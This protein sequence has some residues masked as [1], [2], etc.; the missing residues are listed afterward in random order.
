MRPITCAAL[1][2]LFALA[3][4][5]APAAMA[6]PAD[7]Q[8]EISDWLIRLYDQDAT[9]Y[10]CSQKLADRRV[11]FT[12]ITER[13]PY[14]SRPVRE[15]LNDVIKQA[16][17][18][19]W[20]VISGEAVA[21]TVNEGTLFARDR[22]SA[23]EVLAEFEE[24]QTVLRATVV[25]NDIDIA[26]LKLEIVLTEPDGR[27]CDT[28]TRQWHF[29]TST[30]AR[31]GAPPF[32]A[33]AVDVYDLGAT[34][35]DGLRS[36]VPPGLG[37]EGDIAFL[38]SSDLS[39]GRCPVSPEAL[40]RLLYDAARDIGHAANRAT[41]ESGGRA[42][43][44]LSPD[45]AEQVAHLQ[46]LATASGLVGDEAQGDVARI[47][48]AWRDGPRRRPGESRV[49]AL[50]KG[51]LA[52]CAAGGT[53][54][55]LNRLELLLAGAPEMDRAGLSLTALDPPFKVGD[56]L[57][58]D[59][60]MAEPGHPYCWA[61]LQDEDEANGLIFYPFSART[62]GRVLAAGSHRVP[63][64][65]NKPKQALLAPGTILFHCF[66]ARSRA[67]EPLLRRWIAHHEAQRYLEWEEV[68]AM[69]RAFRQI[70]NIA[71]VYAWI[72]IEPS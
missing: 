33:T 64:G 3:L 50:P 41:A 24:V 9:M 46:V 37:P 72:R 57:A 13:D 31:V 63:E 61:L 39:G 60:V 11:R 22:V 21:N 49:V 15:K 14:L 53:A 23:A 45:E 58:L 4:A 29:D 56:E 30:L 28:A 44:E 32:S 35:R 16:I 1:G 7:L 47:A 10:A 51:T 12:E 67:P 59:F 66:V 52:R 69:A 26:R 40:T 68:E 5:V 65:L 25:R 38:V 48:F 6:Q 27:I 43:L 36:T 2:G 62:A 34:L 19:R 20:V 42:Y 54:P 71:E 18:R 8:D 55:G 17:P 70:T